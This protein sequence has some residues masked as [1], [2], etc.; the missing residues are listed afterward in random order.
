VHLLQNNI[1]RQQEIKAGR[2]TDEVKFRFYNLAGNPMMVRLADGIIDVVF[3][4]KGQ[5]PHDV[6]PGAFIAMMAGALLWDID[7]QQSVSDS[8]SMN[9]LLHPGSSSIK[10]V[11]A[12]NRVV[13]SR[14]RSIMP[15]GRVRWFRATKFRPAEVSTPAPNP[16]SIPTKPKPLRACAMRAHTEFR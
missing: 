2:T 9:K 3:D 13:S 4:L 10:Y 16:S 1:Q 5:R 8:S 14:G 15:S 12:A 6:V 7:L 11:L